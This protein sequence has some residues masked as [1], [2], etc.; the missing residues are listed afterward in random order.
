[1]DSGG[2]ERWLLL[3]KCSRS[4]LVLQGSELFLL[5]DD[6]ASIEIEQENNH[7]RRNIAPTN[8]IDGILILKV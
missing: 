7:V 6:V 4:G 2:D 8:N 1:M 5:V 3:R